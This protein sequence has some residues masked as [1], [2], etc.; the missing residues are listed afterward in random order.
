MRASWSRGTDN[1]ALIS[2]PELPCTDSPLARAFT[3]IT[4][5]ELL[6]NLHFHR[7]VTPDDLDEDGQQAMRNTE[8]ALR[9]VIT[10]LALEG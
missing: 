8:K 4:V 9:H 1:L 5:P 3:N 10:D 6:A 2:L 7:A